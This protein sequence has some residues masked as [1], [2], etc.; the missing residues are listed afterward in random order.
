MLPVLRPASTVG[1]DI[2]RA[3]Q[4]EKYPL[5]MMLFGERNNSFRNVLQRWKRTPRLKR[6]PSACFSG[7]VTWNIG[8]PAVGRGPHVGLRLP[9]QTIDAVEAVAKGET[10]SEALRRILTNYLKRSGMLTGPEK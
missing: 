9:H 1:M 4:K 8:I 6:A 10:R 5:V 7:N 3:A 2:H